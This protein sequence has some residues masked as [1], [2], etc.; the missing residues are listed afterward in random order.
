[1]RYNKTLSL[2][3]DKPPEPM[4]LVYSSLLDKVH[5]YSHNTAEPTKPV[6]SSKLKRVMGGQNFWNVALLVESI[7]AYGKEEVDRVDVYNPKVEGNTCTHTDLHELLSTEH[8]LLIA[9]V[10]ERGNELTGIFWVSTVNAPYIC[11]THAHEIINEV[12][13]N[14]G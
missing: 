1:M 4:S 14:Y 9:D 5:T 3:K 12:H 13:Q 8:K 6:T 10:A 7:T 2:V 11:D